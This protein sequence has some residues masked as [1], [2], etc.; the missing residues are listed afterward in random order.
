MSETRSFDSYGANKLQRHSV[1]EQVLHRRQ[2]EQA[3]V[4]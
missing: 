4:V 3:F 1:S 2:G